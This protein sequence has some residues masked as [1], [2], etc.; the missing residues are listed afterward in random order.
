MKK[1]TVTALLTLATAFSSPGMAASDHSN[2]GTMPKDMKMKPHAPG[3]EKMADGLVKK[4]D[5][6]GGKVTIA[7]GPLANLGMD[8]PMTM[9]FRVK[10]LA[11]LDQMKAGE[12]IRF[13]A[14]KV[15]GVI[16]IVQFEAAK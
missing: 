8:M 11:W 7:H 13:I 15:N 16:T 3:E 2:H 12:K 14:D 10:D 1:A 5:K 9:V 6:A 4:I